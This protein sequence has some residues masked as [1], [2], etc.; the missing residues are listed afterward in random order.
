MGFEIIAAA[1]G[2]KIEKVNAKDFKLIHPTY[3]R[4]IIATQFHP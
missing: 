3:S 1:F 2:S 4:P